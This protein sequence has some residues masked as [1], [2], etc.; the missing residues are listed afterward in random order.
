MSYD[1]EYDSSYSDDGLEMYHH[2]MRNRERQA[3]KA[4]N[5]EYEYQRNR[6]R[7][8]QDYIQS[9]IPELING[10]RSGKSKYVYEH[11]SFHH[12]IDPDAFNEQFKRIAKDLG[13][14][15]V[16]QIDVHVNKK[17]GHAGGVG[18]IA[19]ATFYTHTIYID[20]GKTHLRV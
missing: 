2:E 10:I 7:N 12:N 17:N 16:H 15:V 18:A 11:N 9:K 8:A 6:I 4:Q 5:R 20:L 19:R 3:I 1:Y 14:H 13:I